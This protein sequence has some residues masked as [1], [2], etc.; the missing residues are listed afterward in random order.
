MK[1]AKYYNGGLNSELVLEQ[2]IA[3]VRP[4]D[5]T[6]QRE[7]LEQMVNCSSLE[8]KKNIH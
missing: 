3:S 7:K 5:W 4:I 2:E 6:R 1:T 8:N